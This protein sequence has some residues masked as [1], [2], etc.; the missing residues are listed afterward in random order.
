[1]G[2]DRDK[3]A[4]EAFMAYY[5]SCASSLKKHKK[6]LN[7]RLAKDPNPLIRTFRSDLADLNDGGKNLRGVLVELGYRLGGGKDPEHA[8]DLALAFEMFQTAVLVH[9]DIIDNA[10]MRRGKMTIQNRYEDRLEVRDIRILSAQETEPALAK[11]AA[12]CA[13]DLGL[14][15]S[16]LILAEAYADDPKANAIIAEFDRV[17]IDT[18]RGELLDVV[19]PYELQ[20]S[21][22]TDEQRAELLEKSVADIYHLKTSRYSVVGPLHLGLMLAGA[23]DALIRST[24]SFADDI[25]IAYQIMD[26]ILGIYADEYV[27]GKDVGSDISEYKQTILYMYV[28]NHAPEYVERL[29]KH[30]GSPNVTEQDVEK[31]Q[32]I[33]RESGALDYARDSM[34]SCFARAERKISRLKVPDEDK[35]LLRG[36]IGYCRGRRK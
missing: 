1:M 18:I 31:V 17:A 16:N 12:L 35:M 5:R 30:Y 14:F 27:L 19:L 29:E 34:N 9:D 25:G 6:E 33:F 4:L 3:E 21:S 24:D 28:K 13:G 10:D 15:Y 32:D 8:M 2:R 22:Y 36:F 23:D 7:R 11:S 26:D 20:D